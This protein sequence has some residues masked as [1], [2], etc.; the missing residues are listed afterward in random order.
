MNN[1]EENNNQEQE[2]DINELEKEQEEVDDFNEVPP[3]DTS[4][5][6]YQILSLS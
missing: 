2:I 5:L 6:T 4:C 1:I 3:G